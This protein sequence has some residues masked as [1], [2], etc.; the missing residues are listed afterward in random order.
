MNDTEYIIPTL[1]SEK[2]FDAI[3][4]QAADENWTELYFIGTGH[5]HVSV[6]I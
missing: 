2:E 6:S 5:P 4:K 1:N 3:L